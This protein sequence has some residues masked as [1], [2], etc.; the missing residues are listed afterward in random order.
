M[1]FEE[2]YSVSSYADFG[3]TFALG[4]DADYTEISYAVGAF[5]FHMVNMMIL[6]LTFN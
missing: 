1:T 3:I 2:V 4:Q 5:G 6:E